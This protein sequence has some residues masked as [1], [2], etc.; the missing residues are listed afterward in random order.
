MAFVLEVDGKSWPCPAS[1]GFK[2]NREKVWSANTGRS[3]SAKMQG[4]IVGIKT[5]L[6]MAFPPSVTSKQ[7]K[8][9]K[10]SV[11]SKEEW[12]TVK[13]TNEVGETE[14][15]EA[16]FGNPSYE[17]YSFINGKMVLSSISI[18]AVER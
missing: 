12:H 11:D 4:K 7:L 8:T 9:I 6:D 2:I 14:T 10:T 18:Q 1:N 5:T 15:I 13:F 16:Y 3:A 17:P